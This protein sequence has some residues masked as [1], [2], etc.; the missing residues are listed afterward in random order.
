MRGFLSL[1][2]SLV[3]SFQVFDVI[4]V[5]TE[6]GPAQSTRAILW[7]IYENAFKFH[8][9]G[10]ASAISVTLFVVLILVTLLQMRLLRADHSDLD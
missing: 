8:K 7:Y 4:A 9:M 10:Y 2:T 3:G 1:V 5:T 6:G